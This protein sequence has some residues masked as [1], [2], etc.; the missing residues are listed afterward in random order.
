VD[1]KLERTVGVLT[2]LDLEN[3]PEKI[4]SLVK[5]LENKTLPLGKG[6]IGVINSSQDQVRYFIHRN[7]Y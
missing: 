5:I 7:N 6:Y 1:S 2:K 3:D 4:G